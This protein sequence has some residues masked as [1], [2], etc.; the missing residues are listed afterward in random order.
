MF[1]MSSKG[2]SISG[3]LSNSLINWLTLLFQKRIVLP[4]TFGS[5]FFLWFSQETFFATEKTALLT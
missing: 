1:L 2:K 5:I 4:T 3:S